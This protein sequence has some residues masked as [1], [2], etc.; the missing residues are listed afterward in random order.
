M[1]K[2]LPY[3]FLLAFIISACSNTKYLPVGEKLYTGAKVKITD[4]N[5]N[6]KEAKTLTAELTDLTR[7]KPNASMLG[8]RV[9]LYLYNISKG[10]KNFISRFINKRGEPPVLLSSVDIDNNSKILQN[11][12]ENE[13]YF[14]AQVAGDSLVK[15]DKTGQAIYTVQTGPAYK[16]KSISF[17]TDTGSLDTAVAGTAKK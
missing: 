3:I 1:I 15:K 10:K 8:L 14:Q 12:L 5:T 17:P 16:I 7:P 11:R 4:K 9:K 6:K 13:S 2:R